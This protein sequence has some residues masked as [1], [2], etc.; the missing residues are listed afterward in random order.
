[1]KKVED[2][3][4]LGKVFILV[5]VGP[6]RSA[7]AGEWMRSNVPGIHIPDSIIKRVA[8]AEKQAFEGRQ[9]C[10]DLIQEIRELKGVSG[11]H[12]MAYRQE[13]SV[14]EIIQKSGVLGGRT[15]W[16]PGRDKETQ[17][18]KETA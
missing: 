17:P 12:V 4:L 9:V 8:G 7:K 6:L 2:L 15:P 16:Y 11:I 3:G 1:M 18:I 14:A 5:G 13:E 10:I